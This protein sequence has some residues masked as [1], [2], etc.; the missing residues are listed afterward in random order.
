[1]IVMPHTT[2]LFAA[3][4]LSVAGCGTVFRGANNFPYG[5][6]WAGRNK[7]NRAALAGVGSD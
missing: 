5:S 2:L 6:D 1:M 3:G 7:P 4:R